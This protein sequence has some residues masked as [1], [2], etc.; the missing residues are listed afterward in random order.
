[1]VATAASATVS[2]VVRVISTEAGLS[3]QTAEMKVQCIDQLDKAD[4]P[5]MLEAYEY[6]V[7]STSCVIFH[8]KFWNL[9]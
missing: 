5:L 8:A 2:N 4:A 3:V 7:S 9:L 1:M 6:L